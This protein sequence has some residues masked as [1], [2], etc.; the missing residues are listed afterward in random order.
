MIKEGYL[1]KWNS[2]PKDEIKIAVTRTA[3]SP[4]SPSWELLNDYKNGKIDWKQY[5]KRFKEE[6]LANPEALEKLEEIRELAKT[7]TVRLI[8]YEKNPPCHRFILL[9]MLEG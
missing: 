1:A 2:Y 9:E 8:C 3:K 6:I 5:T 4:L 7:K